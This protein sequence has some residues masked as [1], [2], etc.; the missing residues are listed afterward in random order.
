MR[1]KLEDVSPYD[2]PVNTLLAQ[3]ASWSSEFK[4]YVGDGKRKVVPEPSARSSSPENLQ[5]TALRAHHK[6]TTACHRDVNKTLGALRT[7]IDTTGQ[8]QRHTLR[9][10]SELVMSVEPKITGVRGNVPVKA[11]CGH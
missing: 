5:E 8:D 10:G 11:V 6:H 1:P 9:S 4:Y 3:W 7:W 2:R